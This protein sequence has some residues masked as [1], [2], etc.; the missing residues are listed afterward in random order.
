M[1]D[2]R[3]FRAQRFGPGAGS[4]ET[5][6]NPPSWE[7]SAG[8]R[9]TYAELG[10]FNA[11]H[12][13]MPKATKDDRS[14]FVRYAHSA[15][16]LASWRRSG[17]LTSESSPSYYR[18]ARNGHEFLIALA[19]LASP[20]LSSLGTVSP[21]ERD[22]RQ[23]LLEATRAHYETPFGVAK[24]LPVLGEGTVLGELDGWRLEAVH[25]ADL[26]AD[27]AVV[28]DGQAIFEAARVHLIAGGERYAARAEAWIPVA[29]GRL[30]S[31]SLGFGWHALSL[32]SLP[33]EALSCSV[34]EALGCQFQGSRVGLLSVGGGAWTLPEP[35]SELLVEG[36]STGTLVPIP[37]EN[38][39]PA[40]SS[41]YRGSRDL[42]ARLESCGGLGDF[43][44]ILPPVGGRL[45]ELA[46]ARGDRLKVG[47]SHRPARISGWVQWFMGDF[48]P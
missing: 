2:L 13:A 20:D 15:A 25:A 40:D 7:V 34:E 12:L 33:K 18:F 36:E 46:M 19:R 8:E 10:P 38:L 27:W 37:G 3:P 4:L 44:A 24:G 14:K 6:V 9:D 29:L 23:R 48:A 41:A 11:V 45:A 17:E 43:V 22:D 39:I 42:Q 28:L 16:R 35:W 32:G 21:R 47:I 30:E 31:T 1:L 26:W 5:L